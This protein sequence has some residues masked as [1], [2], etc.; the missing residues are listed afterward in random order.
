[1]L[2][3]DSSFQQAQIHFRTTEASGNTDVFR[4]DA[5]TSNFEWKY[6][7]N[8]TAPVPSSPFYFNDCNIG[9]S[10]AFSFGVSPRLSGALIG[11]FD[12]SVYGSVLLNSSA[13]YVVFG[14]SNYSVSQT[15]PRPQNN[16]PAPYITASN[17]A[18]IFV[19]TC[20]IGIGTYSP[21]GVVS[22]Y[23][24]PQSNIPNQFINSFANSNTLL[25]IDQYGYGDILDIYAN[26]LQSVTI[27]SNGFVGIGTSN[28]QALL[29]IQSSNI[30]QPI[31]VFSVNQLSSIGNVATLYNSNQVGLTI[32]NNG[33]V[34]VNTIN[35]QSNLHVNGDTYINGH[36]RVTS[37]AY[38]AANIEVFGN[39][40]A[41]G[42]NITDS[43]KRIKTD[44]TRIE[45]GLEK[46][47]KLTGYTFTNIIT[48]N[49]NTG[50]IAQDVEA[51]LPEAVDKSRE[52]MG[53]AY[54]NLMGLVVE[55]IKELSDKVDSIQEYI[56]TK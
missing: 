17:N 40:V 45:S 42:N 34:G 9:Y 10:N 52:Y 5:N 21:Q 51:V 54:G 48:G 14:A 4:M 8:Y 13:P 25:R 44:L 11:D 49:K 41:H 35:P 55:A 26:G 37:N 53:V 30:I 32:N 2:V 28:P 1:M 19:A 29:N 47:K 23:N 7:P 18:L 38:F 24:S 50:L 31:N 3:L 56:N 43:D 12:T 20:N 36:L 27:T 15:T 16:L 33:F 22:I 6:Y 39:S 46:L